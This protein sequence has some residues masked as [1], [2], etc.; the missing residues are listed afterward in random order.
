MG[1]C[2]PRAGRTRAAAVCRK[3]QTREGLEEESRRGGN[4]GRPGVFWNA[5]WTTRHRPGIGTKL[6]IFGHSFRLVSLIYR[7]TKV[8]LF[9]VTL[10][11]FLRAK[12][13]L[14]AYFSW[15]SPAFPDYCFSWLWSPVFPFGLDN[16]TI[17]LWPLSELAEDCSIE[18]HALLTGHSG[19]VTCLAFSP[20]GEQLLSGGKDKVQSVVCVR[21]WFCES[22][23]NIKPD[24]NQNLIYIYNHEFHIHTME[25]SN[26]VFLSIS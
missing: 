21:V 15:N 19:G 17:T 22:I 16:C 5:W 6:D 13:L 14:L 7:D 4:A 9:K 2:G 3:W 25:S 11:T 8:W 12:M 26:Q 23:K 24:L 20:D 18:P 1:G 10:H